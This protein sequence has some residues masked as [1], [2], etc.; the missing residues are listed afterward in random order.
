M[1]PSVWVAVMFTD[2]VWWLVYTVLA[3]MLAVVA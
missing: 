3:L 2:T 1:L